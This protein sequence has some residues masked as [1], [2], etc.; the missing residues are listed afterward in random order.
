MSYLFAAIGLRLVIAATIYLVTVA[1]WIGRITGWAALG[2][3]GASI[4][5]GA[6][7]GTALIAAMTAGRRI[8]H[9]VLRAL[10]HPPLTLLLFVT[11]G[12][13]IAG[14]LM[15]MQNDVAR[16]M[17]RFA[18]LVAAIA[19]IDAA[20]GYVLDRWVVRKRAAAGR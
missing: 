11:L 7:A 4:T 1:I 15:G 12:Y 19:V 20:L 5:F 6:F 18:G 10:V 9:P 14:G 17:A 8:A 3:F 16:D 2:L 13:V